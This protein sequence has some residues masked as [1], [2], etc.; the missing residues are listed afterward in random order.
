MSLTLQVK[1]ELARFEDTLVCC[2]SWELK[3]FLLRS[4][5]YTIGR[6]SHVISIAVDHYAV[7][8]RLFNLIRQAG[9]SS[10]AIL[11]QQEKRLRKNRFLVSVYGRDQL[12]AL[13]VYLDLKEAGKHLSLPRN[14]TALPKRLCCKKSVLR[15]AFLV[16]GSISVSRQSGYH[17]EI[18][19]N[20]IEDA[21]AYQKILQS[22]E[23]SPLLR[24]RKELVSLYLKNAE[25]IG[26]FLRIVGAGSTLLQLESLR[27]VS[28]MRNRVNRL[29]NCETANLERTVASAHQQ[30]DTIDRVERLVGLANISPALREA[31]LIRRSY[32]EASLKELGELIEPPLSKSAMSH[33][34]RQLEKILA[35][36]SVSNRD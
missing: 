36:N 10:P 30:L 6:N 12:E 33:R 28:S 35:K 20:S 4:G 34:F 5:Y 29:V 11:R 1:Q 32:P 22:F 9:V 7:A 17:L 23:I 26:D 16:G 21:R 31:A 24:K 18:G 2:D 3:A 13:L 15:G 8:R 14:L 25:A 19:C 27:V